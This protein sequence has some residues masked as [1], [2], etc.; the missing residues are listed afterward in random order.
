ML[1]SLK[2][3]PVQ[4]LNATSADIPSNLNS[5][6]KAS[7]FIW[8]DYIFSNRINFVTQTDYRPLLTNFANATNATTINNYASYSFFRVD[9]TN[10]NNQI[11]GQLKLN[12]YG[13]FNNTNTK[14]NLPGNYNSPLSPEN[15]Q[16]LIPKDAIL[17]LV[18][19]G[20]NFKLKAYSSTDS[21]MT[22]DDTYFVLTYDG[23]WYSVKHKVYIIPTDYT[24][25]DFMYSNAYRISTT[26]PVDK[27][28]WL[29]TSSFPKYSMF[30]P[31]FDG[32]SRSDPWSRIELGYNDLAMAEWCS[33]YD[34]ITNRPF[35][36]S[37]QRFNYS[38]CK[39][40]YGQNNVTIPLSGM[41]YPQ[42]MNLKYVQK[43]PLAKETI[44]YCGTLNLSDR[45]GCI[46]AI[47]NECTGANLE[48]ELCQ[49][50]CRED[51]CHDNLITYCKDVVKVD[52]FFDT[53]KQDETSKLRR[54]LCGCHMGKDFYTKM[55]DSINATRT[56]TNKIPNLESCYFRDCT[57]SD[58]KSPNITTCP[59]D[60]VCVSYINIQTDGQIPQ[61]KIKITVAQ[62]CQ[63][64]GD[65]GDIDPDKL[66][67][68]CLKESNLNKS[69]CIN[70]CNRN[71]DKCVSVLKPYCEKEIAKLQTTNPNAS[72]V[73]IGKKNSLIAQCASL[74][75]KSF[76][77]KLSSQIRDY[78]E[79]PVTIP[80]ECFYKAY[81]DQD[82]SGSI[83]PKESKCVNDL[84]V[85]MIG[86]VLSVVK[87]K[88]TDEC[89]NVTYKEK[90]DDDKKDDKKGF[91]TWG[92]VLVIVLILIVVFGGIG[93]Y[94]YNKNK[95]EN[96]V[97]E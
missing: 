77:T 32:K 23:F 70:Y 9:Y 90:K 16:Q 7:Y 86:D 43:Y 40:L 48:T 55:F 8:A 14:V 4:F 10:V 57:L 81:Q 53:S 51:G 29:I 15:L 59:I 83:C 67:T 78:L 69:V 85:S 60:V 73:E 79:F 39:D 33:Q 72:I 62:D 19:T 56:A 63:R 22:I 13:A 95:S 49:R 34:P 80:D 84:E 11:Y 66:D 38:I 25:V 91:P 89:K 64:K 37:D 52:N 65:S 75:P 76:Y 12:L 5:L 50:F 47:R 74:M 17:A 28:K 54:N 93:F 92:W 2:T 58:F 42:Y 3:I 61:D 1:N 24:N 20:D 94:F 96:V 35:F 46:S 68:E 71:R 41:T 82:V 36:V 87:K 26:P 21:S 6:K 31:S 30:I 45:I 88:E 27:D 44:N 97:S 18:K